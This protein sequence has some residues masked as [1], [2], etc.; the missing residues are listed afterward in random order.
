MLP[1]AP[2]GLGLN[3]LLQ[4]PGLAFH[5]PP[6]YVGYVGLSVA[7]M[8]FA[9]GT[10]SEIIMVTVCAAGLT[11]LISAVRST[12]TRDFVLAGIFLVTSL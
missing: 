8:F 4:D 11:F 6:L 1:A 7:F 3:P 10:Y 12:S 9:R 2:E 5:P